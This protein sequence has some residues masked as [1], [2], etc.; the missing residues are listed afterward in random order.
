ML[1]N[2]ATKEMTAQPLLEVGSGSPAA[3][4]EAPRSARLRSCRWPRCWR[5]QRR[6][7]HE[8]Y[9]RLCSPAAWLWPRRLRERHTRGGPR[10][11][12]DLDLGGRCA[13]PW[14]SSGPARAALS[15]E[16]HARRGPDPEVGL[17]AGVRCA[18]WWMS[19]ALS[20]A[21]PSS[22]A[23]RSAGPRLGVGPD[24]GG[25]RQASGSTWPGSCFGVWPMLDAAQAKA[26]FDAG[27]RRAG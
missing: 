11:Q 9:L 25:R 18:G 23:P 21:A 2:D 3:S 16:H 22:G 26:G 1:Q 4:P 27:G 20:R 15:C 13:C 24:A 5:T 19:C 14:M 12:A 6:P 10:P 17:N 7:E 8:H